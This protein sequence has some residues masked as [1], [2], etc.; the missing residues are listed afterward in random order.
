MFFM[1]IDIN[2]EQDFKEKL[3]KDIRTGVV[4]IPSPY[5]KN[6]TTMPSGYEILEVSKGKRFFTFLDN[7]DSA[8]KPIANY[9]N[10]VNLL[11][12]Y[13][14]RL[15]F[16]VDPEI[17]FQLARSE[18]DLKKPKLDSLKDDERLIVKPIVNTGQVY[19][20]S[21]VAYFNALRINFSVPITSIVPVMVKNRYGFSEDLTRDNFGFIRVDRYPIILS[22]KGSPEQKVN[23]FFDLAYQVLL[24]QLEPYTSS[25]FASRLRRLNFILPKD[26]TK[27][28]EDVLSEENLV[29]DSVCRF[30]LLTNQGKNG[31][32]N[33][34]IANW[35]LIGGNE[36]KQAL[37][38]KQVRN[39]GVEEVLEYYCSTDWKLEDFLGGN[40]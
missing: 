20:V 40:Y 6:D 8:K 9:M 15:D 28:Q 18:E 14:N 34:E 24:Q 39:H 30:I 1:A 16:L 4:Y 35:R 12:K 17:D 19:D 13:T 23:L 5:G 22:T 10:G 29:T 21:G 26:Y 2:L 38:L 11:R 25:K 31:F 3:D 33:D 36:R 7:L 27:H 32:S 37:G